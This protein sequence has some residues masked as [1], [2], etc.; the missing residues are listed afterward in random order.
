M[1]AAMVAVLEGKPFP[2]H[3]N[4]NT[5]ADRERSRI[6]FSYDAYAEV[7][8]WWANGGR[9][10]IEKLAPHPETETPLMTRL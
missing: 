7:E 6:Q 3:E 2:A 8:R 10:Q 9:T 4:P 1:R 5:W